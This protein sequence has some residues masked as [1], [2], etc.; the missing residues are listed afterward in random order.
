[1]KTFRPD[2]EPFR[3]RLTVAYDGAAFAGWQSQ[4]G[5]KAVQD[6]MERSLA[7]LAKQLV[8]VHGAGRTD[9]GVHALAQV[10]HFDVP[11]TVK[12]APDEWI[13]A[14]N[15]NLP[16]EIRVLAAAR[17]SSEF[18]ARFS[19]RG[20]VYRYDLHAAPVLP[21]HR[22]RRAW[23]VPQPLDVELLRGT[24]RM[25]EGRHDFRAFAA[26]RGTPVADT[27]RT[28]RSVRVSRSG[29]E[30]SLSFEGDG[31][32]YKMVRMLV[33]AA[34]RVGMGKE[35]SDRIRALLAASGPGKW[36]H[37]APADGLHLVRVL[38]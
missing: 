1:V 3:I 5:G 27:F 18:H 20:K 19:A 13:R 11:P 7:V 14:L 35:S 23:H 9:A 29:P 10:A 37:V 4:S 26:N 28:I 36:T 33:G 25:F 34:V 22:F 8:R 16:N 15:A 38:Y 32:L 2:A 6:A 21:P 30:I 12:L 24:A 31:F 17:A